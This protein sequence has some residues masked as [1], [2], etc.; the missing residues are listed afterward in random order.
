MSGV[1]R[2][3]N[4]WLTTHEDPD[5]P[6]DGD[7]YLMAAAA[8]HCMG[9]TTAGDFDAAIPGDLPHFHQRVFG[10][11]GRNVAVPKRPDHIVL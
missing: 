2:T 6:S 11:A 10:A 1:D 8:N 5:G 7:C 9:I 3:A 4:Q